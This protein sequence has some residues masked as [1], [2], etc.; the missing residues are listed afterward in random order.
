MKHQAKSAKRGQPPVVLSPFGFLGMF[1]H[2]AGVWVAP[3]GRG[4]LRSVPASFAPE[5]SL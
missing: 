4:G 5:R 1:R 3:N 2:P